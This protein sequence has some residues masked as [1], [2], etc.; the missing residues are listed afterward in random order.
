MADESM[1]EDLLKEAEVIG[2]LAL[3]V[4]TPSGAP[5]SSTTT[6]MCSMPAC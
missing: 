5:L 1:I 4:G 6:R 2:L 3:A